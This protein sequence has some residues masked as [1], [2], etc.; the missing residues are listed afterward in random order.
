MKGVDGSFELN[1][2]LS[3]CAAEEEGNSKRKVIA[4]LDKMTGNDISLTANLR[5]VKTMA[6]AVAMYNHEKEECEKE[7]RHFWNM[8]LEIVTKSIMD[9]KKNQSIGLGPNNASHVSSGL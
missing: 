9:W 1:Y 4:N 5:V 3:Q 8:N 2:R 7:D 6:P